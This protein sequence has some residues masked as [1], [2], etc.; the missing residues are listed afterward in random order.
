[1]FGFLNSNIVKVPSWFYLTSMALG[2]LSGF[3]YMAYAP[4]MVNIL[5]DIGA[6]RH[7]K[8]Y[9]VFR[10]DRLFWRKTATSKNNLDSPK[11]PCFD[12]S[13]IEKSIENTGYFK[14]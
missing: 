1:M 11:I 10:L 13:K 3:G 6:N 12:T 7:P 5:G 2:I 9:K 4:V 14:I 8:M